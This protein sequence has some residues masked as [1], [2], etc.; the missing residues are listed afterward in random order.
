[1]RNH[2]VDLIETAQFLTWAAEHDIVPDGD[3]RPP[4]CLTYKPYRGLS[5]FWT[6][7]QHARQFPFFINHMLEGL[8]P[9]Q[10]CYQWIRG[11]TWPQLHVHSHVSDRTARLI[12]SGA[13]IPEGFPG[14]VRAR[15]DEADAVV[16]IMFAQLLF[17]SSTSDDLFV[18]PDTAEGMLYV[19]H[20]DVI[21]ADFANEKTMKKF[22]HHM[23]VEEYDLPT[24][25]PDWTFKRP[26]WMGSGES[27]T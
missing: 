7:P 24:E 3:S 20:H 6:Q 23:A 10:S 16:A 5:R 26:P 9:W 18:I 1:M 21:H 15:Y 8:R 19:D 4:E 13:G 27:G 14:A 11:G 12:L 17:G 22:I 25:R 2:S